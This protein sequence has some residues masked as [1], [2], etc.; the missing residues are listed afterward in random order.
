MYD[1][2]DQSVGGGSHGDGPR[3]NQEGHY[4]KQ[5]WQVSDNVQGV[6][7]GQHQQVPAKK[8]PMN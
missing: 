4:V 8:D 6:V 7:E 3:A 2:D 5:V 1:V